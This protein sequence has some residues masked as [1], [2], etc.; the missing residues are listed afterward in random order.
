M[1]HRIKK[2]P[3]PHCQLTIPLRAKK[4]P[5]CFKYTRPGYNGLLKKDRNALVVER[6]EQGISYRKI[7]IEFGITDTRVKQIF[8]NSKV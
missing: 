1:K 3:C 5:F 4:C 6:V 2:G 8:D 7:G